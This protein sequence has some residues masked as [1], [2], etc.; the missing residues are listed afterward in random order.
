MGKVFQSYTNVPPG[1]TNSGTVS[2][3]TVSS[4]TVS[5]G[6]ATASNIKLGARLAW[7]ALGIS[8]GTQVSLSQTFGSRLVPYAPYGPDASW[9]SGTHITFGSI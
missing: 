5:S 6:T 4:G 3:G 7:G 2:S 8:T 9:P 1:T